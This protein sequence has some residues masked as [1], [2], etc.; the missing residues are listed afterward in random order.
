M[1]GQQ[2]DL[3]RAARLVL[4]NNPPSAPCCPP[5]IS[6]R[7]LKKAFGPKVI[8]RDVSFDVHPGEVFDAIAAT[9]YF[10]VATFKSAA[11]R[12]ELLEAIECQERGD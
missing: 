5:V 6:F 7:H 1:R 10:G 12:E 11:Y 9:T 3:A 4:D 2:R 8:L